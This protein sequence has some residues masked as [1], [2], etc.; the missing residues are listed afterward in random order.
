MVRANEKARAHTLA[1]V[2]DVL[3]MKH[4]SIAITRTIKELLQT[5]FGQPSFTL[6]HQVIKYVYNSVMKEMTYDREHVL[7]MMVHFNTTELNDSVINK[8]S[9]VCI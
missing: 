3:A 4:E 2:S 8:R 7:E 5:M 1:S 9:Q 6:M